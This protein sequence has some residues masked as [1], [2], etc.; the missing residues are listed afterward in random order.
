[1]FSDENHCCL[2]PRHFR[3][4]AGLSAHTRKKTQK[5]QL[6]KQ[7]KFKSICISPHHSYPLYWKKNQQMMSNVFA[8]DRAAQ[9]YNIYLII[10]VCVGT[11]EAD[12]IGNTYNP[13]ETRDFAPFLK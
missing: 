13:L 5:N 11:T 8:V 9:A 10:Y 3:R 2:T 6:F 12:T 7:C 1:M 4:W